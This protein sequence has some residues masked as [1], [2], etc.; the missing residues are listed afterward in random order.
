M[1]GVLD[2]VGITVRNVGT[3]ALVH[4]VEIAQKLI[5]K[6]QG[7]FFGLPTTVKCQPAYYMN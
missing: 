2:E 5:K 7:G 3:D 4:I 1:Y 6:I